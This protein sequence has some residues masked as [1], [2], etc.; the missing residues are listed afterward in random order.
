MKGKQLTCPSCNSKSCYFGS[1]EDNYSD[2]LSFTRFYPSY[3]KE[4]KFLDL[5]EP[6]ISIKNG[7]KFYACSDCGLL[8]NSIDPFEL[9]QLFKK[10]GFDGK[11]QV[12]RTKGSKLLLW[13]ISVTTISVILFS[14]YVKIGI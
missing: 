4:P 11:R 5:K 9:K 13:A 6:N 3:I 14:V 7:N 8:W 12:P 10:V 1:L 2:E